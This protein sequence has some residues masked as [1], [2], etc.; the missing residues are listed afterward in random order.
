[1]KCWECCGF[2]HLPF[3]LLHVSFHFLIVQLYL[4]NRG[5]SGDASAM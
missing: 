1:M 5:L 3:S 2:D 4:Y